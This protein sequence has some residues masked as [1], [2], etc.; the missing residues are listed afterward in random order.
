MTEMPY[1][2]FDDD[3]NPSSLDD[4]LDQDGFDYSQDCDDA[5]PT[6]YPGAEEIVNNGIDEDCDGLDLISSTLEVDEI[7]IKV[8]P[9]PAFDELVIEQDGLNYSKIKLMT[10]TGMIIYEG[11][12]LHKEVINLQGIPTGLYHLMILHENG[13]YSKRIVKH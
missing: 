13:N 3:C 5:D 1:N 8:Y 7:N 6:I 10:S 11:E 2:G 12:L 9:N 4:D